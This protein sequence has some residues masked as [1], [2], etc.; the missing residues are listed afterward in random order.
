MWGLWFFPLIALIFM[1]VSGVSLFAAAVIRPKRPAAWL[2]LV[3]APF[4]CAAIPI[5]GFF[6][7]AGIASATRVSDREIYAEIFGY[8]PTLTEDRM[9]SDDFGSGDSRAI[10]LRAEITAA[11]RQRLLRTPGLRPS[12]LTF[13]QANVTAY[14]HNFM[15]WIDNEQHGVPAEYIDRSS[16]CPDPKI[17]EANGYNGWRHLTLI[18]CPMPPEYNHDYIYIVA[19]RNNRS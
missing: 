10:Y 2:G 13:A 4:G 12:D 3:S 7:L 18:E 17:Y 11:E 14:I 8:T 6:I 19:I 9:L 1:V 16:Q 5:V 15:W